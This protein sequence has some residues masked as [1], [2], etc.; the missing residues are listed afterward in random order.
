M[1][2]SELELKIIHNYKGV[3][4][5]RIELKKIAA[6]HHCFCVEGAASV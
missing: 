3:K 4:R 2:D 1:H 5:E 6:R